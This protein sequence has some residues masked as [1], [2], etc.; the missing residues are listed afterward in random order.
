MDPA[1]VPKEIPHK[2]QTHSFLYQVRKRP[3]CDI[4]YG[5]NAKT[6]KVYLSPVAFLVSPYL[7][8]AHQ[9]KDTKFISHSLSKRQI[10]R[11]QLKVVHTDFFLCGVFCWGVEFE[12]QAVAT[13]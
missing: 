2:D 11:N 1:R 9:P 3:L 12:C 10:C 7:S 6:K 4:Y 5:C 8:F 13:L